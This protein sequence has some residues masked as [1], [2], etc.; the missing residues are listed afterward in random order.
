MG[1]CGPS[2]WVVWG[3]RVLAVVETFPAHCGQ[4]TCLS[5]FRRSWLGIHR[6]RA[7]CLLH[8]LRNT[9]PVGPGSPQDPCGL[10]WR[11]GVAVAW[12]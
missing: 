11:V 1:R 5:L 4:M 2:V 8:A 7:R 9:V 3:L 12:G 10:T 6:H